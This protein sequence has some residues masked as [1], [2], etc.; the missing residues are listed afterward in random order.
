[1]K[2][3]T[4]LMI[5]VW[6]GVSSSFAQWSK[7]PLFG[8]TIYGLTNIGNDLYT[9]TGGGIYKSTDNGTSWLECNGNLYNVLG[10][11]NFPNTASII[12]YD[13]ITITSDDSAVYVL[14]YNFLIRSVDGG[15]SW[16]KYQNGLDANP[17]V[18][19]LYK[20][21][22]KIYCV[23]Y[24]NQ[25]TEVYENDG[26]QWNAVGNLSLPLNFVSSSHVY[27][28]NIYPIVI[29]K[30]SDGINFSP[31]NING[32]SQTT[33]PFIRGMA[34]NETDLFVIENDSIIKS[35]HNNED[36]VVKINGLPFGSTFQNLVM[37]DDVLFVMVLNLENLFMYKST[38]FGENWV[39]CN[40]ND[41]VFPY[42]SSMIKTDNNKLFISTADGVY[43]SDNFGSSWI[44]TINGLSAVEMY[45]VVS[46]DNVLITS[47]SRGR[48]QRSTDGGSTWQVADGFINKNSLTKDLLW[49][50]DFL[51]A[52]VMETKGNY[53]KTTTYRSTNAGESWTEVFGPSSVNIYF[54]LILGVANDAVFFAERNP[55][56]SVWRS[57]RTSDMINFS[58]IT[59]PI[60]VR[61]ISGTN[62][63]IYGWAYNTPWDNIYSSIDSGNSWVVDSAG[64]PQNPLITE[65]FFLNDQPFLVSGDLYK[66]KNNRWNK[67]SSA[68]N[69]NH[70]K[71]YDGKV[72]AS[73]AYGKI[74]YSSDEGST[75]ASISMAG[76]P[77]NV[78]GYFM[79]YTVN[80]DGIYYSTYGNGLWHHSNVLGVGGDDYCQMT[81]LNYPNPAKDII[82]ISYE[83]SQ[84]SDV[85]IEIFDYT[86]KSVKLILGE[87]RSASKYSETISIKDLP[88]GIYMY[89]VSTSGGTGTGK[90]VK[91]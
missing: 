13:D 31:C 60:G 78:S 25:G 77:A 17:N 70:Y 12:P 32:L 11:T 66:K 91:M 35:S 46:K 86:G 22:E 73:D 47:G 29:E 82:T 81:V 39:V 49:Y 51:L 53:Y 90:I 24:T 58:E 88:S 42:Y 65:V 43:R 7:R 56:D 30:S 80:A 34:G 72:Y 84:A 23:V 6:I 67:I 26:S 61:Y 19:Y 40:S 64:L 41:M 21:K 27:F 9:A 38:D 79:D 28:V 50:S 20:F 74:F 5:L 76:F 87:K 89:K 33:P 85:K 8:G 36:W 3:I 44:K 55:I 10:L 4:I 2:K 1:M 68:A 16:H 63:E 59:L 14:G 83:I 57:Y 69:L 54:D 62:N 37:I 52:K 18:R 15:A 75:W 48:I 45:D 71:T